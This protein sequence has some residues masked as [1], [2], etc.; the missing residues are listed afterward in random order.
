VKGGDISRR[1]GSKFVKSRINDAKSGGIDFLVEDGYH[2]REYGC[3]EAGASRDR[4]VRVI[5]IAKAIR[6]TSSHA[7]GRITGAVEI[8]SIAWRRA[9]R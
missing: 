5:A 7:G 3:G 4:K 8:T 2:A 1:V 6:A 9:E